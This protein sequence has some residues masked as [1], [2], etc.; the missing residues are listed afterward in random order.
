MTCR[1]PACCLAALGRE[2]EVVAQ[3]YP[4]KLP[5]EHTALVSLEA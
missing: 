3:P 2:V 4:Y 5:V 1:A